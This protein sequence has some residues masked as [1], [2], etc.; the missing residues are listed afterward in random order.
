ME[1][2]IAQLKLVPLVAPRLPIAKLSREVNPNFIL[3]KIKPQIE[4]R[5][6]LQFRKLK[7]NLTVSNIASK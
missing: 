5:W 4:G 3:T 1:C 7:E 6:E 2:K